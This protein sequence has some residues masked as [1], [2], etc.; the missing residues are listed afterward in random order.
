MLDFKRYSVSVIVVALN[1]QEIAVSECPAMSAILTT[2]PL[3]VFI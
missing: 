1:H 3:G 2:E